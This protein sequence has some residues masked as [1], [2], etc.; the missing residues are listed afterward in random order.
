MRNLLL[1]VIAALAAS[2]VRLT[3]RGESPNDRWAAPQLS[4][5]VVIIDPA[6]RERVGFNDF[7]AALTAADVVF[8]GEQ[9]TDETT[10]RLQ[11]EVLNRL[12]EG[13]QKPVVLALEMFDRD[14]QPVLDGYLAG[15]IKEPEFLSAARPWSNYHE[16]YR[17]LI[18]SAKRQGVRVIASNFPAPIRQQLA[19]ASA[20]DLADLTPDQ[21][22]YTPREYFDNSPE[23]WKRVDNAVRGHG[24]MSLD[25]GNDDRLYTAQSL[26]DNSMG[27]ACADALDDNPGCIVLHVNGAF[28]SAHWDG[29][30]HQ[31]RLRKPGCKIVTVAIAPA[32]TPAIQ[33]IV[34]RPASDFLALVE[35]RATNL[36]E[37]KR[38]VSVPHELAYQVH[39]PPGASPENPA[40]LLIWLSD[41]GLTADEGL[42]FCRQQ[43]GDRS[44]IIVVEPPY[45]ETQPDLAAGGRWYWSDT[46]SKDVGA[47]VE[48][49]GE[50]WAYA[51]R[52]FPVDSQRV[53][54][55]G[56]GTGA[57]VAAAVAL[58]TDRISAQAVALNPR[59]FAKLK[60]LPLPLPED[61]APDELPRRTLLVTGSRELNDWWDDELTAYSATGMPSS[62][63]ADAGDP[64]EAERQRL[65]HVRAALGMAAQPPAPNDEGRLLIV[66]ETSPR[67][68][69]WG[70]LQSHWLAE[71]LGVPVAAVTTPPTDLGRPTITPRVSPSSVARAG[72]VPPCPG[73]FGGTTIIVLPAD[74][75]EAE[76]AQWAD[77]EV[78]D[79]LA[80]K[81]RFHRLRIATETGGRSLSNVLRKLQSESRR[82]VLVAPANFYAA[83]TWMQALRSSTSDFEDD[84]TIHWSPGLGGRKGALD[85]DHSE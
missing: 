42:Q 9:H 81:S 34:G 5:A 16:A 8:L 79:P 40:P 80:K 47:L 53:C 48:G 85:M 28:H 44:A 51:L 68:L 77:L 32:S 69:H 75:T 24:G 56:E 33:R 52:H 2:P 18:E 27:E 7:I 31:L 66:P 3:C 13:K 12:I 49:V 41:D 83:P 54:L 57:T 64:W 82:N 22:Q 29:A 62:F 4:D 61:Y 46:F 10:H 65:N 17:P 55:A 50:I 19:M 59:Q 37:G 76:L 21:R 71:E 39:L 60:D 74:A 63:A 43:F 20:Q 25:S 35:A 78:T 58:H 6:T 14:V 30:V 73:P 70:R 45:R 67:A 72:V 15:N 36:D 11:L 23:Y 38:T 1:L 84:M 26:W